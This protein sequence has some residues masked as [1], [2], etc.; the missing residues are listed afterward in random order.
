MLPGM[1]RYHVRICDFGSAV[2]GTVPL[3]TPEERRA[4]DDIVQTSTTQMYRAPEMIDVHS[5]D[6]LTE[7]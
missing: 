5:V 1:K 2:E 7:K 3:H 6:E 4:A